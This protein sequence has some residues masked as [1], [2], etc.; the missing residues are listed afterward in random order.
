MAAPEG[1]GYVELVVGERGPS[2]RFDK[3]CIINDNICKCIGL[4][5][6]PVGG[7]GHF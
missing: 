3:D 4:Y 5:I 6:R 1:S 2:P 7:G